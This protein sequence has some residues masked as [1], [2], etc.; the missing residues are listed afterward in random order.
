MRAKSDEF[1]GKLWGNRAFKQTKW[2]AQ[3]SELGIIEEGSFHK[4]F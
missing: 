1:G 2:S 4:Q 3:V